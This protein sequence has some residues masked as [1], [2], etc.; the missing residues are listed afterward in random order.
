MP[1]L[2]HS[3]KEHEEYISSVFEKHNINFDTGTHGYVDDDFDKIFE[4]IKE[5]QKESLI[6]Y[7]D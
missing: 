1:I 2:L 6:D 5:I 7:I 4:A 3:K